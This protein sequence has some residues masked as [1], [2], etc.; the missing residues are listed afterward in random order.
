MLQLRM[1][2]QLEP[3]AQRRGSVPGRC[4]V[5]PAQFPDCPAAHSM[6][7]TKPPGAPL[8]ARLAQVPLQPPRNVTKVLSR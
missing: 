4:A 6:R 8:S 7:K 1:K 5:N 3:V 2:P